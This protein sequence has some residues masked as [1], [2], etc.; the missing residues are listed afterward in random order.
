MDEAIERAIYLIRCMINGEE[1]HK[2]ECGHPSC[3]RARKLLK[4]LEKNF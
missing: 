3:G 2:E 4:Y 1:I